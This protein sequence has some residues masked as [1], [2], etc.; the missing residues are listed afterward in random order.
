MPAGP[1][2]RGGE[3]ETLRH[4]LI[5]SPDDLSRLKRSTTPGYFRYQ[6]VGN[7]RGN[8]VGGEGARK[9]G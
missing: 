4:A 7:G 2:E 3:A 8:P 1:I 9:A 5:L 6:G